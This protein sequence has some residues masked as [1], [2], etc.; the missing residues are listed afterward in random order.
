[1]KPNQLRAQL[2][3]QRRIDVRYDKVLQA[4]LRQQ[5]KLVQKVLADIHDGDLYEQARVPTL[6]DQLRREA[7][8]L[9]DRLSHCPSAS[10]EESASARRVLRAADDMFRRMG[11]R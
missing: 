5:R 6:L 8:G 9:F 4:E 3:H 1:M 11:Y 10:H 2:A 7:Q